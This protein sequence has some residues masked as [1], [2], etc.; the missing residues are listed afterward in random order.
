MMRWLQNG[1]EGLRKKHGMFQSKLLILLLLILPLMSCVNQMVSSDNEFLEELP[2]AMAQELSGK[3]AACLLFEPITWSAKD[4]DQ[5]ISEVKRHNQKL[6][7][8]CSR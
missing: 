3:M 5:T 2:S 1:V 7:T 6:V 4:T 8:Y